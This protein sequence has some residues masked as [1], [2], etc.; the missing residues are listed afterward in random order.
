MSRTRERV[1]D[2]EDFSAHGNTQLTTFA[3]RCCRRTPTMRV[4]FWNNLATHG[5]FV[6]GLEQRRGAIRAL[7]VPFGTTSG[8]KNRDFRPHLGKSYVGN[9]RGSLGGPAGS[10]F[11]KP[12]RRPYGPRFTLLRNRHPMQRRARLLCVLAFKCLMLASCDL[13]ML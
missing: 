2:E 7:F 10:F 3:A 1:G 12:R 9:I 5:R 13:R 4:T 6:R 8:L 11:V